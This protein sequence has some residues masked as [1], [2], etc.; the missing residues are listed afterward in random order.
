[1]MRETRAVRIYAVLLVLYPRSHRDE[2]GSDMVQLFADRY[3]D[4]RPT[5]DLFQFVRFWGGMIGD[6]FKTVL[7]ERT[8]SVMSNFKQNWWKWAIG[9]F[10]GFQ[11]VFAVEAVVGLAA[12]W[13]E[14]KV[15]PTDVHLIDALIPITGAVVLIVGLKL[16]SSQPRIAAVLLTVGLLPVALVGVIFFWFPPMWLVSVIGI[17][18]IVKVYMEAGRITR[19]TPAIAT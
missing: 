6:I 7:A 4:E 5:V 15:H 19:Q 18:L 8:E 1:M 3:R 17:Y 11:T 10:A 14:P 13:Q 2:Y 16:L 12:G 9:V